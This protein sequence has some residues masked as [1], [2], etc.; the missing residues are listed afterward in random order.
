M[1]VPEHAH[2]ASALEV[3]S[4]FTL[5]QGEERKPLRNDRVG[6]L[7]QASVLDGLVKC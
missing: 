4:L 3:G 5:A 2:A 6:V 1:P 7:L